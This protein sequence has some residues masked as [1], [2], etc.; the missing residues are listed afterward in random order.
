MSLYFYYNPSTAPQY[1]L[2][3][4]EYVLAAKTADDYVLLWQND[5]SIIV[6]KH[7]NT[8]AEVN[9]TYV[10]TH[11]INVVRRITGG[12]AVY[13]DLGNLNFSFITDTK[14]IAQVSLDSFLEP[15]IAA[16][17]TLGITATI[18]GRNDLAIDGKKISGNAQ[19][20][21]KNRILHHGTL[22]FSAN[23]GVL[24]SALNVKPDKLLSKGVTSVRSRVGNIVDFLQSPLTISQFIAHLQHEFTHTQHAIEWQPTEQDLTAINNLVA[25]KYATWDWN[26]GKSPQFTLTNRKRFAGGELE[27]FLTI[28]KGI[29]TEASFYG[30]F[31]TL[32]PAEQLAQK[33]I[34]IPYTKEAVTNALSKEPIAMYFNGFTLEDVVTC[35]WDIHND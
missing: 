16:L 20:A 24:S 3:L 21:I 33:L 18:Q 9:Q 34:N 23:L 35:L 6:G 17:R 28:Q 29:I 31:L 22:L 7:Q 19:A 15:V 30:D 12:G 4:E 2:A 27:V 1:N 10:D 14:D 13:H 32:L 11:N 5:N 25:T 8:A 26:Y